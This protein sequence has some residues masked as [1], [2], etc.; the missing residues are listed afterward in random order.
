MRWNSS[1]VKPCSLM[2]VGVMAGSVINN[3][4]IKVQSAK[5]F[6]LGILIRP[7]KPNRRVLRGKTSVNA[8]AA[9]VPNLNFI[10]DQW[11]AAIIFLVI[12][13][14]GNGFPNRRK[15]KSRS[16]KG[17]YS[18]GRDLANNRSVERRVGR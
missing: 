11:T 1:G 10:P 13:D 16:V 6:T 8:V 15:L 2:S 4:K 18:D 17:K 14:E 5:E 7:K 9:I 12:L 3:S